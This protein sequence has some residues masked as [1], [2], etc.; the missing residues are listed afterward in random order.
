MFKQVSPFLAPSVGQKFMGRNS[1]EFRQ[2]G[3]CRELLSH[4]SKYFPQPDPTD[5]HSAMDGMVENGMAS[6]IM[7]LPYF[8][9][10]MLV[11]LQGTHSPTH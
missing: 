5:L 3:D 11:N 8:D 9:P 1:V 10:F 6:S 4:A 2:A 7:K